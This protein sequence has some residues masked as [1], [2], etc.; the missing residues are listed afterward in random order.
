MK[1]R[2]F[3]I[4]LPVPIGLVATSLILFC[5]EVFIGAITPTEALKDVWHRQFEDI[6]FVLSLLGAIPFVGL[7]AM[8]AKLGKNPTLAG[9]IWLLCI[10]GLVGILGVMVPAHV[11]V[12]APSYPI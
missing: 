8:L 9:R 4:L 5:V 2:W 10:S 12:W 7:T 3:W 1:S 11:E 6:L